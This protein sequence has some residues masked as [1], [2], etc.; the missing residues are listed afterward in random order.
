MDALTDR[1]ADFKRRV[2]VYLYSKATILLLF[3]WRCLQLNWPVSIA[4]VRKA[5]HGYT[6]LG[7][8]EGFSNP[9]H[10]KHMKI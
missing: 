8:V 6:G 5:V 3:S 2:Y 10:K 7:R 9:E 1:E 4:G